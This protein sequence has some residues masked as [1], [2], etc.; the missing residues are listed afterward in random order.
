MGD[1]LLIELRGLAFGEVTKEIFNSAGYY[2]VRDVLSAVHFERDI[3]FVLDNLKT[4]N[5]DRDSA[6]WRNIGTRCLRIR[7]R[8]KNA[9]ALGVHPSHMMC[10][11]CI[12]LLENAVVTPNGESYCRDCIL[13]QIN[14]NG[15]HPTTRETLTEAQLIPN[16]NLRYAV[17]DYEQNYKCYDIV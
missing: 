4:V 10:S 13:K 6:Y 7:N 2:K 17:Q 15:T 5:T 11:I 3:Q 12:D 16:L 8:L 14:E 1:T 9:N